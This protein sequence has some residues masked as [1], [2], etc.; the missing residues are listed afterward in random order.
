M[1]YRTM[2][3]VRRRLWRAVSAEKWPEAPTPRTP[4]ALR[5]LDG[6]P[7]HFGVQEEARIYFGALAKAW[8]EQDSR[9]A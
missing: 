5:T 3:A 4:S 1:V 7:L 8:D 6:A 2:S 9:S